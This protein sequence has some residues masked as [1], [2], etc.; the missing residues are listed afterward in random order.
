[1]EGKESLSIDLKSA[2]GRAIVHQLIERADA[3]VIGFRPGVAE[4]LGIDYESLRAI[5]PK[6]VY[7]HA[8]GYG[9]EGPYAARPVYASTALSLAGSVN[10]H[11]GAWMDPARSEGLGVAELQAV[12]APHL[13]GPVDGD[14]NAAL[15]AC[16]ALLFG[17]AH[18][19]RTG[20]GQFVSTSM[21]G[22]NVYAYTDDA[23]AY[24]GKPPVAQPDLEHRGLG[25]LYRMYRASD[26]WVFLAAPRESEWA[27][28]LDVVA[29]DALRAA[30][31][32]TAADRRTHDDALTGVLQ[33]IFP[34]RTAAE[35]ESELSEAGVGC[36]AVFASEFQMGSH[37]A[38][39]A[40]DPVMFETGMSADI[41]HP[42]F[43]TIRRHGV[44][45]HLSETP[46][47]VAPGCLR[48]QHTRSI[49]AELGYAPDEIEKLEANN[50]VFGPD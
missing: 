28:L 6:L 20:E 8:A 37:P 33:G 17:L 34:G 19:R 41:E 27:A 18:Q 9:V 21:I 32:A 13:R 15:A 10:R 26:A 24:A 42:L 3:F 30:T 11:A 4:R 46:G 5:N 31:F 38:F 7:V 36:A 50:V 43:G 45:A 40:E 23:V 25:A 16:T 12:I 22:G 39:V 49:L 1:M 47:R 29:D 48:G 35:W 44:P 2:E 14:S